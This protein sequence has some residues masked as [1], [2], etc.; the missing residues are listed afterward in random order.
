MYESN[1]TCTLTHY[2]AVLDIHIMYMKFVTKLTYIYFHKHPDNIGMDRKIC[3]MEPDHIRV[4]NKGVHVFE[5][6][7]CIRSITYKL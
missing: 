2:R 6:Q 1:I 4:R 3:N 7:K 5:I